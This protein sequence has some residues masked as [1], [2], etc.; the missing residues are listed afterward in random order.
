MKTGQVTLIFGCLVLAA[1]GLWH[2]ERT[3]RP[4]FPNEILLR[5]QQ[6]V[7]HH[8]MEPL[9]ML[10]T[11]DKLTLLHAYYNLRKYEDTVRIADS[12]ESELAGLEPERRKIFGGMVADAYHQLGKLSKEQAFRNL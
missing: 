3:E 11:E 9:A 8:E 7:E 12:M 4:R 1:A 10:A 5:S 2:L 6:L